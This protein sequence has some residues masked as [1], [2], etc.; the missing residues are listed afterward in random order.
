MRAPSALL[1]GQAKTVHTEAER[2]DDGGTCLHVQ[3]LVGTENISNLNDPK[4]RH[5]PSGK[6]DDDDDD[7]DD[8]NFLFSDS[9]LMMLQ[10]R[11]V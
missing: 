6:H 10:L 2:N 7:D 8:S 5:A 4:A 3:A 9:D 1:E 11:L